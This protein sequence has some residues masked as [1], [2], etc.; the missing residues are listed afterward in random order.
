MHTKLIMENQKTKKIISELKNE[1]KQSL[2]RPLLEYFKQESKRVETMSFSAPYIFADFSKNL[3]SSKT[4]QNLCQ[5]PLT[6]QIED[7]IKTMFGGDNINTTEIRPALHTLLR[8]IETPLSPSL[9]N[10]HALCMKTLKQMESIT[11]EIAEGKKKSAFGERI[12]DV[13]SIGI[14]G[15]HLGP[16]L[17]LDA[18]RKKTSQLNIHFLE[19]AD[20]NEI[21]RVLHVLEPKNTLFLVASKSFSTGETLLNANRAKKWLSQSHHCPEDVNKS[22]MGITNNSL[23][24]N[25]FGISTENILPLWD[26]VG[27]RFSVWS[28]IGLP[29]ALGQGMATFYDFLAGAKEMD[30]HFLNSPVNSNLPI[31]L[32]LLSFWNHN[33]LGAESYAVVPYCDNLRFFPNYL[34]QLEMESN[35]KSI[36][37]DGAEASYNTAPIT[38]GGAGTASQH[39]FFQLLHQGTRMVPVDFILPLQ[40]ENFDQELEHYRVASCL[41][42]SETLM[43]G[44]RE[45]NTKPEKRLTGSRPSTTLMLENLSPRALG[46]LLSLYEHKTET[47]GFLW[48]INSFDQWGVENGK[49]A[50]TSIMQGLN[51]KNYSGHDQSTS[52]LMRKYIE[53]IS[54]D[55]KE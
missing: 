46:A 28:A 39:A 41:A 6:L 14:G 34:Q 35:G 13:V 29:I 43:L 17:I 33:C 18:L 10:K 7:K 16:K 38:W 48:N 20:P 36:T 5:I 26:W 44:S 30:D 27:G 55:E 25:A 45:K 15:S 42:Q 40:T 49:R 11:H 32:A 47:L 8:K 37:I 23:A 2:E 21:A 54:D 19:N 52:S 53:R 51:S 9:V 50:T 3:L 1:A 22:F 24:A 12:T 4:F 31:I